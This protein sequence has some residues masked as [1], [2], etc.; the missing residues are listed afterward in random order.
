MEC[1]QCG[2]ILS[3]QEKFCTYCGHYN[4]PNEKDESLKPVELNSKTG[5]LLNEHNKRIKEEYE[6][7]G[8]FKTKCL[9]TYLGSDYKNVSSGGFNLYALLFSWIYFIN[10]KMYLI[11]IIGLVI[12][13]V[14]VIYQRIALIVFAILSMIFSGIFFNKI[15][16]STVTKKVDKIISLSDNPHEILKL[17]KKAGKDNVFLTLGIYLVFLVIIVTLYT[18]FDGKIGITDK[19][20]QDNSNNKAT[21]LSIAK[22]AKKISPVNSVGFLIG[23]ECVVIDTNT[24]QYEMYLKFD[25]GNQFVVERYLT[26]DSRVNFVEGTNELKEYQKNLNKLNDT[27]KANYDKMIALERKYKQIEQSAELEDDLIKRGK[28]ISPKKYFVLTEEEVNR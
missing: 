5:V 8:N 28:N 22:A 12:A 2:K 25:K 18:V 9:K 15:Y 10:K 6:D 27:E 1:R 21:C 16:L 24:E 26:K 23:A 3:E 13:G 14:L 20:W 11:G 4:D 19:F 17:V 7:K